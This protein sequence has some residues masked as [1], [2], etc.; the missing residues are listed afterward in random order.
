MI[1]NIFVCMIFFNTSM[2]G[3]FNLIQFFIILYYQTKISTDFFVLVIIESQISYSMIKTLSVELTSPLSRHHLS[4]LK[5]NVK[6]LFHCMISWAGKKI[7]SRYC[8]HN[9]FI[10]WDK[11]CP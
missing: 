6:N 8:T 3:S 5:K 2:L 10:F 11:L 1:F 4:I 7:D 9:F